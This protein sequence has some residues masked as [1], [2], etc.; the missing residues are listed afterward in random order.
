MFIYTRIEAFSSFFLLIPHSV[1][2][3]GTLD[4]VGLVNE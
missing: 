2:I 1:R 4:M 3:S